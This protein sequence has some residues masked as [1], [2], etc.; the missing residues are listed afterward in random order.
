MVMRRPVPKLKRQEKKPQLM[1]TKKKTSEHDPVP[2][3]TIYPWFI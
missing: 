1:L 3:P 2:P